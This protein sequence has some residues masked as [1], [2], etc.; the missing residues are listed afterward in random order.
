MTPVY[1]C[2]LDTSKA[3]D[4]VNHLTLFAKLIETLL[5]ERVMLFWYQKQQ[6]CIKW[7]K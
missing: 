6:V 5:I 3:F 7:G 2:L 1:T 4:R